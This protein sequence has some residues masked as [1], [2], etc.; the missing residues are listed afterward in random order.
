MKKWLKWGGI[1]VLALIVLL[2]AAVF[3]G[4][5]LGERKMQRKIE[6]PV[7]FV[8]LSADAA[9]LEL[10]RYLFNSRGCAECHG[11][12][13]GGHDVIKT[14]H[15][16][17]SA[18]NI[19]PGDGSAV[20]NYKPEDWVRAIRHGVKP[21]GRPIMVMPSEDYN[22]LNDGD[23]AAIISYAKQLPPASGH[24]AVVQ[25]PLP[26]TVLYGVGAIKDA[27]EKIDHTLPP[28]LPVPIAV[29]TQYGAY[30]ANTCLGCHGAHLSGGKIPGAPPEW[31]AAANLT[32]GK[33]SVLPAYATAQAFA[34]MFRSGLR[35]DG[36]KVSA[37]MPFQSLRE[38]NDTDIHALYAYLKTVTPRDAGQR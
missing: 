6:A 20:R 37:V 13:G 38:M 9:T 16:L 8:T 18:P 2:A 33:G 11:A 24:P 15:M 22:R 30:V 12:T 23:V 35:P 27:A 5:Q 17:V 21:D 25:L 7:A 34:A 14:E 1:V 36:S 3:I 19:T 29:T 32:P 31:P 26:V 10:G 4:K 28:S